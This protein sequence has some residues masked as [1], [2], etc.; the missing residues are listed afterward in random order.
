MIPQPSKQS[1]VATWFVFAACMLLAILVTTMCVLLAV[2]MV[3]RPTPPC[4]RAEQVHRDVIALAS[5]LSALDARVC[6]LEARINRTGSPTG[7]TT[8]SVIG[9]QSPIR[10]SLSIP[11]P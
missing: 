2:P 6:R 10:E 7:S 3:V 4:D 8:G 5:Q 9:D 11:Q 1:S